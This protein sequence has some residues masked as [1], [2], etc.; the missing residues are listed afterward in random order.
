MKLFQNN[1]EVALYDVSFALLQI[2]VKVKDHKV[3]SMF[4]FSNFHYFA[5]T[6]HYEKVKYTEP[7]LGFHYKNR[8]NY[9]Q[10]ED[11]LNN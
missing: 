11:N 3:L 5:L 2:V 4:L 1:R 6:I 9:E 8:N 7:T 10:S